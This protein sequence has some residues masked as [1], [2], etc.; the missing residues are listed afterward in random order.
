MLVMVPVMALVL[1]PPLARRLVDDLDRQLEVRGARAAHD[2]DV[3]ALLARVGVGQQLVREQR[4]AG[5]R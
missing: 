1:L 2:R 3:P 4:L 5:C